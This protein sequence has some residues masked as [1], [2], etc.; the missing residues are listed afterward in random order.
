MAAS[1]VKTQPTCH[2]KKLWFDVHA[3]DISQ[4]GM[5]RVVQIRRDGNTHPRLLCGAFA[6]PIPA[7]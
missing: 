5:L 2:R 4:V 6:G 3:P 1:E 7:S